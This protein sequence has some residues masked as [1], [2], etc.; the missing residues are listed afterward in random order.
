[1]DQIESRYLLTTSFMERFKNM[2]FS[3]FAQDAYCQ[4]C[5][6]F[7]YIAP[8]TN[9]DLFNLFNLN[10]PVSDRKQFNIMFN[11]I[12]SILKLVEHYKLNQKTGL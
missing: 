11:Q 1:M 8:S 10:T 7:V 2:K 3:F 5:G 6:K 12:Y 4:F 9:L